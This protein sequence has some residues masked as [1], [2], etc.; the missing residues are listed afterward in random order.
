[1]E[2]C[3]ALKRED[4]AIYNHMNDPYFTYSK[5]NE[6]GNR[7]SSLTCGILE[8]AICIETDCFLT[9]SGKLLQLGDCCRPTKLW[10]SVLQSDRHWQPSLIKPT[11]CWMSWELWQWKHFAFSCSHSFSIRGSRDCLWGN[12]HWTD[13]NRHSDISILVQR[14]SGEEQ[15]AW[16]LERGLIQV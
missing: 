11:Q 13:K 8:N 3:S 9:L 5:W 1:M 14:I 2:Y 10:T 4:F 7:K 15:E 16:L 12:K 6:P